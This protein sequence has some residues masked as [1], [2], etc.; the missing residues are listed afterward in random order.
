[1]PHYQNTKVFVVPKDSLFLFLA[2]AHIIWFAESAKGGG[3]EQEVSYHLF[4]SVHTFHWIS[5][6]TPLVAV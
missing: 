3:D 1:M 4:C 5:L 6:L 2:V